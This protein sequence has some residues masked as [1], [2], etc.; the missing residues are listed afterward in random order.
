MKQNDDAYYKIHL[1]YEIPYNVIDSDEPS[2]IKAREILYDKLK[3][4]IPEKYERFSVKLVLSQLKDTFNYLVT[5]TA[6]F[7]SLDGLPMEEYVCAREVK[8][9]AQKEIEE[10]F[11]VVDCEFRQVNKI[12]RAHV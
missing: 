1:T 10:F 11:E 5:Y 7:R 3:T 8:D 12:G 4:I 6:F 2:I 9:A